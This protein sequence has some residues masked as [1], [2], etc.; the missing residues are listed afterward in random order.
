MPT[1]CAHC[2]QVEIAKRTGYQ[3][4]RGDGA[5]K[6]Y[7]VKDLSKPD[8]KQ[9]EVD[10]RRDLS[11]VDCCAHVSIHRQPC[12]H[13]V[14]VFWKQGMM[15]TPRKVRQ[16]VNKFWPKWAQAVNYLQA[17]QEK[18]IA[19]PQI[20]AGKFTGDPN[21]CIGAPKQRKKKPGR[22]K[23]KRFTSRRQTVQDIKNR[24]PTVHHAEYASVLEYF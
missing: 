15:S 10:M 12:R 6:L 11:S 8:G 20:Y 21:D 5:G 16:V 7:Y 4:V 24:L 3:V 2:A 22:P 19:R 17:Y 23:K 13:M 9:Y 1:N 18:R 14:C